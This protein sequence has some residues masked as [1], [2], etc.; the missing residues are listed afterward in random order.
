MSELEKRGR[1]EL[2]IA[3]R[4][5]HWGWIALIKKATGLSDEKLDKLFVYTDDHEPRLFQSMRRMG[6]S[7]NDH[8]GYMRASES[9]FQRVHADGAFP[10]A[11]QWFE[12]DIW[13][14]LTDSSYSLSGY[15][16]YVEKFID[17]QGWYRVRGE[18]HAIARLSLG[19]EDPCISR[20]SGKTYRTMLVHLANR[21]DPNSLALLWALFR[22]AHGNFILGEELQDLSA[23]LGT[24]AGTLW[25]SYGFSDEIGY[26]FE[27]LVAD[28]GIRNIWI[29]MD[30]LPNAQGSEQESPYARV[31]RFCAWYVQGAW[32]RK[33]ESAAKHPIVQ[34]TVRTDWLESNRSRMQELY[35]PLWDYPWTFDIENP[36]GLLHDLTA[37]P[38]LEMAIE[39]AVKES[40]DAPPHGGPV[41]L[42]IPAGPRTTFPWLEGEDEG[43]ANCSDA[44]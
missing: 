43:P 11:K 26:L 6:S 37:V 16:A 13:T 3:C 40:A 33:L 10:E 25:R 39:Q 17:V 4:V 23:V 31:R 2:D 15:T 8:K 1:K 14:F 32:R 20:S 29:Q 7:P 22:E 41:E 12:S 24:A 18:D 19:I 27:Q 34:R 35:Q 28:R 21:R 36:E 30:D 42:P 9:V 44:E 38:R 5:R